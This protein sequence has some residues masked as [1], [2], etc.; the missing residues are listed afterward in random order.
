MNSVTRVACFRRYLFTRYLSYFSN[1]EISDRLVARLNELEVRKLTD[2]QEKAREL[3]F[4][5]FHG[6]AQSFSRVQT[7]ND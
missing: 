6:L 3:V 4:G 7:I 1:F 2:I 5:A